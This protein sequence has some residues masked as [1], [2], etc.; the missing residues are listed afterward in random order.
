MNVSLI[1]SKFRTCFRCTRSVRLSAKVESAQPA[2]K[3]LKRFYKEVSIQKTDLN[4]SASKNDDMYHHFNVFL[5]KRCLK[6]PGGKQLNVQNESL[7]MSIANEWLSQ[8]EFIAPTSMHFTSLINTCIDNPLQLKTADIVSHLVERL[9]SDTIMSLEI[10]NGELM[11]VQLSSLR[12]IFTWVNQQWGSNL[13]P[14]R[15]L[16]VSV[17]ET[18][19]QRCTDYLNKFSFDTLIGLKFAS[20]SLKSV[21]LT[22]AAFEQQIDCESAVKLSVLE[23]DFQIAK[24]GNV[25]WA[26]DMSRLDTLSR[27]SSAILFATFSSEV[28]NVFK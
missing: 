9:E 10:E 17:S 8:K 26:H 4:N 14:S 2:T 27:F 15:E 20:D 19:K 23:E 21:L 24:W 16:I 5:D 18:C 6:T 12:P 11:Q 7:A 25:E 3:K 28:H 1:T 22:V 13:H